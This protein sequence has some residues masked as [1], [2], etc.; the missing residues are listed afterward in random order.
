MHIF[1][2]VYITEDVVESAAQKLSGGSGPGYTD[3]EALQG[4]LLKFGE[5]NKKLCIGV[6]IFV[7]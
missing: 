2:P 5:G 7:D 1:I 3:S 4:W 6:E